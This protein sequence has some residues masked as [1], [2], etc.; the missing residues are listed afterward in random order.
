MKMDPH[1][2][3]VNNCVGA[4]NQ[5]HFVLFLLYVFLQ[6]LA[7]VFSLGAVF[8]DV[9]NVM[10]LPR[11]RANRSKSLL[12]RGRRRQAVQSGNERDM[13]DDVLATM[14]VEQLS[15]ILVLFIAVLFGLFTFIML[16][17]QVAN[18]LSDTTGIEGLQGVAAKRRSWRDSFKEVMGRG[19][20]P[21]W[22]LPMPARRV[23]VKGDA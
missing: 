21:R 19:P 6:C 22:L 9:P 20:S 14:M 23:Q 3:W 11:P 1:C 10:P 15:C 12:A 13:S 17:D 2:P 5:K 4:R 18:I 8:A 16:C 7:A